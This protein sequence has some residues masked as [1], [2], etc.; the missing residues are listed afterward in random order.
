MF[1]FGE[2]NQIKNI[3]FSII[4][5][6]DVRHTYEKGGFYGNIKKFS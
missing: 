1:C 3:I 6:Q 5:A 2:I 4:S